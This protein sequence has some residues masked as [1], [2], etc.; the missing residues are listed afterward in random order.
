MRILYVSPFPPIRDGIGTYTKLILDALRKQGHEARVIVPREESLGSSDALA[1][2]RP[3]RKELTALQ[4]AAVAWKPDCIH[5]QFAVAAFGARTPA[6]I[7]WLGLM[8]ATGIPVVITM[9]E[10]TRDIG[11][12]GS[13]GKALYRAIASK[14]DHVIVHTQ[15]A[16]DTCITDIRVPSANLTVI[17]HPTATPPVEVVSGDEL[18]GRFGLG[19]ADILL[20][21]GFIHVDK[22]LPDIVR[23]LRLIREAGSPSL[24]SVKLVVAGTVRRRNGVFRVFELRDQIHLR[25]TLRMA[26]RGS[27]DRN[28][29]LAGYVPETEIAGWFRAAAAVVLPYRRTEQSGVAALA[30]AFGRPVLAS[31]VGGLRELYGQSPWTF[32]PA[33]PEKLAR[34]LADFLARPASE[35]VPAGAQSPS[36]DLDAVLAATVEVYQSVTRPLAPGPRQG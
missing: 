21:F 20:A 24:E 15:S 36:A 2:L 25:R 17:P 1:L 23:A 31:Q 22:G 26:R 11:L 34:V 16:F 7:R 35:R 14:C 30:N 32:P 10:V 28:I 9:H 33:N 18:R 13:F 6:L 8:R 5:V 3:G 19:G 12:L 27:V 29:V 4:A